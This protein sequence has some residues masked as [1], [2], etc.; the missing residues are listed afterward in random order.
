ML[1][2]RYR[3]TTTIP[4]EAECLTPDHLAGK[5]PA[6]I[7]ALPVQHGNAPAPLGEFFT[8][9][10]D[11]GDGQLRIEGDCRRVKWIGAGMARGRIEVHGD[12]GM[13]TGAE[14]RGGEIEL[15]GSAGDWLGA[16]MRGGRI[17]V[18]G[19]AG[20]LVG[21]TYRGGAVGMRGGAILIDGKAGNEVGSGMRRGLIAVGGDSGDFTGVSLIAGSIF[22]L[23]RPG[24]RP[25]AGMKRGTLVCAGAAP[26]LLP[27]FRLDCEYRPVFLRIYLRQL[28]QWGF[29]IAD[30]LLDSTWRRYSGDLVGLGKGEVLVRCSGN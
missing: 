27:T 14:M 12:A 6:E 23:G 17:H 13:H 16:E 8:V 1:T 22:V 4:V 25:G 24:V 11:A 28:R 18:H 26:V 20:H 21:A 3:G 30:E 10:G 7:A 5:S 15:S 2:L 29:P 9:E 19:D